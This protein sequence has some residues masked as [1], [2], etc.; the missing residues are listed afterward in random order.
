[1]K[2]LQVAFIPGRK[3]RNSKLPLS[4][5]ALYVYDD[6]SEWSV[7]QVRGDIALDGIE[8]I[9]DGYMLTFG[10]ATEIDFNAS[11]EDGL[12]PVRVTRDDVFEALEYWLNEMGA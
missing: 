5:A 12:K 3:L 10:Y 8:S 9:V 11:H 1:M 6:I 7:R 2:E 4:P